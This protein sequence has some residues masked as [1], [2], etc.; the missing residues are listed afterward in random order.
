MTMTSKMNRF[1]KKLAIRKMMIRSKKIV[2]N[3]ISNQCQWP[4]PKGNQEFPSIPKKSTN[5]NKITT[6][7]TNLTT[8][9]S[10]AIRRV[11]S[12]V[13]KNLACHKSVKV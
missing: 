8:R 13:S 12:E 5:N 11:C 3:L 2:T 6:I 9:I 1:P 7:T 4:A 10:K